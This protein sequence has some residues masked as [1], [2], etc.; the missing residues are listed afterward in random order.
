MESKC[1][2]EILR[3]RG[4]NLNLCILRMLEDIFG[5]S[6]AMAKRC[7][8]HID[9]IRQRGHDFTLCINER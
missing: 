6:G 4:I 1:P 8:F 9:V 2:D 7:T 3:M 5:P